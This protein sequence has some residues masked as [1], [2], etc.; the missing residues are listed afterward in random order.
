MRADLISPP[1][2]KEQCGFFSVLSLFTFFCD[3]EM[4]EIRPMVWYHCLNYKI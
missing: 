1:V 4:K 3:R 2:L